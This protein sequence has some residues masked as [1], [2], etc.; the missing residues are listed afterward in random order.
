MHTNYIFSALALAL[1]VFSASSTARMGCYSDFESFKSQGPYTYQSPGYCQTECA[2]KEFKVA[3]LG[4]GNICYCGDA[5]PSESAK[6]ADDMCDMTCPGW[7]KE[8]CGGKETFNIF[9]ATED[10]TSPGNATSTS[11]RIPATAAGGIIVAPSATG[12]STGI[13]TAASNSANASKPAASTA[14]PTPTNNAAG[15]VRAGSSL[16]GAAIAGMGLLL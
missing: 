8:T 13:V 6:V 14:S 3:A 5:I 2:R 15:T 10:T 7:P 4:R 12:T 9:Q 1:P 11:A 16:L